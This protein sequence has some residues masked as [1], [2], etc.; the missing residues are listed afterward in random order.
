MC[1]H[2][3][4]SSVYSIRRD[5]LNLLVLNLLDQLNLLIYRPDRPN[6]KQ[7]KKIILQNFDQL[8]SFLIYYF[9][10]FFF[11]VRNKT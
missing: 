3:Q 8:A 2:N 6:F 4:L 5:Q 10:F 11:K 7:N 9:P 1:L